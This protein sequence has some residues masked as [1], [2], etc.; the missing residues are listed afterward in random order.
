MT[1]LEK[2]TCGEDDRLLMKYIVETIMAVVDWSSEQTISNE[3]TV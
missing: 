3:T 2:N 1:V